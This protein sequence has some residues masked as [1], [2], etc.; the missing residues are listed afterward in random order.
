MLL[1]RYKKQT[2]Q[3]DSKKIYNLIER[4]CGT[5]TGFE[6]YQ[7]RL[8]ETLTQSDRQ[9]AHLIKE[10]YDQ[11]ANCLQLTAAQNICS[12]SVLATLGSILQ[13]KTAEG[14]VSQRFHGG[15]SVVNKAETLAVERAR[16]AFNAQYANVQPHS[17]SNANMIAFKALLK[18]GDK[19]L[20]LDF[21]QGGHTSHGCD[22]SLAKSIYDIEHYSVDDETCLFDYDKIYEQAKETQ[23]KLIICGASVYPRRIDFE[24]FRTIADRVGAFLLADI[25][26]IAGLVIAGVHTSPIDYAHITTTSTYK[27]GGPRGGV[28]LSGKDFQMPIETSAGTLPLFEAIEQATFPGIQGTPYFNNIAAKAVFFKEALTEDYNLMQFK[29]IENAK[30]L[31]EELIAQGLAVVTGGTDNHMLIIDV[32]KFAKGLNGG[33]AQ[34]AL[35]NC[36]IIT[37]SVSLPY[38][39]QA[40]A[41]MGLR[42]GTNIVSKRKMGLEQMKTAAELI[43]GTLRQIQITGADDFHHDESDADKIRLAVRGLCTKHPLF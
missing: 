10:Q 4:Q 40:D 36:N 23:P 2:Q 41:P 39:V 9:I 6:G 8:L 37:D 21:K 22:D 1:D 27:S 32:S 43:A 18:P 5:L 28:I 34:K 14:S 35:E 25:S 11:F 15:C 16:Q 3:K 12:R 19:I 33:I 17:G 20:S 42:L 26:H 30:K 13:N 24:K 31:C 7:G 29:I 38:Q